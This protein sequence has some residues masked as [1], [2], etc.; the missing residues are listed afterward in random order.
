[1]FLNHFNMN[2]K[3]YYKYKINKDIFK[4]TIF[5]IPA[6]IYIF[7]DFH[8]V[9]F[10]LSLKYL[11]TILGHNFFLSAYS[12]K[13]KIPVVWKRLLMVLPL[14]IAAFTVVTMFDIS[15]ALSDITKIIISI[16]SFFLG[17]ILHIKLLK[18]DNYLRISRTYGNKDVLALNISVSSSIRSEGTTALDK[19]S[20]EDNKLYA[21]NNNFTVF[22]Y[23][24]KVFNKRHHKVIRN[25][26]LHNGIGIIIF[27]ICIG[28]FLRLKNITVDIN[29]IFLFTPVILSVISC[30]SFGRLYNQMVFL[31]CDLFLLNANVFQKSENLVFRTFLNRYKFILKCSIVLSAVILSCFG[32]IIFINKV[33]LEI[34]NLLAL[35]LFIVCMVIFFETYHMLIYY[36]VQPYT[37]EIGRASCR[38]RV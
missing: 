37:A 31:H 27:S 8:S 28:L 19:S 25:F 1:M 38:E 36:I 33:S 18:Y 7:N 5:I 12:R 26:Y 35:S 10:L 22:D 21:E 30:I 23:I 16:I 34:S 9:I 2:P 29:Q 15:I 4:K 32:C 17:I 20:W 14:A 3:E 6:L 24:T 11:I 13:K